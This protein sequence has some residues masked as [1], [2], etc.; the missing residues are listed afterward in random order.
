MK[1]M[2]HKERER[3]RERHMYIC[4]SFSKQNIELVLRNKEIFFSKMNS[5]EMKCM[6]YKKG[7]RGIMKYFFFFN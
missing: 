4:S 2:L 6:L 3:E 7:R 5:M 1:C